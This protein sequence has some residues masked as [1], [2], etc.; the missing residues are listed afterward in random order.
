MQRLLGC[1]MNKF[2][3][4]FCVLI[5]SKISFGMEAKNRNIVFV[6]EY[7]NYTKNFKNDPTPIAI[8]DVA[9][10]YILEISNRDENNKRTACSLTHFTKEM[11]S[12]L[13]STD[14]S[15]RKE[16][17]KVLD[18]FKTQGGDIKTAKI[19]IF[20]GSHDENLRESY[21]RFLRHELKM[22]T[23]NPDLVIEEPKNHH[24]AAHGCSIDYV[25]YADK[26]EFQKVIDLSDESK[27]VFSPN[28]KTLDQ[29]KE[30]RTGLDK[31]YL[32]VSA[33]LDRQTRTM[34]NRLD[35]ILG[36]MEIC[37][38][39][40]QKSKLVAEFNIHFVG[41]DGLIKDMSK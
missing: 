5:L 3:L 33:T 41:K 31:A 30:F 22:T 24:M 27:D 36:K 26:I 21:R 13:S 2:N 28:L 35:D 25:F 17:K 38:D 11:I 4:F 6:K 19:R 29:K 10:C 39:P 7:S 32:P 8:I 1:V 20:G 23:F 14:A 18:V 12:V 15:L 40:A 34:N 16:I 37:K 9:T